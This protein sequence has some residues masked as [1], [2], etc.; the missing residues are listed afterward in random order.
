MV[1]ATGSHRILQE[2]TGNRCNMEPI[3]R[4][5]LFGLGYDELVS[6]NKKVN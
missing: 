5:G 1:P 4:A 3:F 2:N 6:K